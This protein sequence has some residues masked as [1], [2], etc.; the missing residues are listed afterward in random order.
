MV[1]L[2]HEFENGQQLNQ[3]QTSTSKA[4][5]IVIL[6]LGYLCTIY[7]NLLLC[8]GSKNMQK[9]NDQYTILT[10]NYII[11]YHVYENFNRPLKYVQIRINKNCGYVLD[12]LG[13]LLFFFNQY[14]VKN[15]P[16]TIDFL[17]L[18]NTVYT[19]YY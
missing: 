7:T 5:A 14:Y 15:D 10:F 8:F 16:Q 4:L 9:T 6:F 13:H 12:F 11:M 19:F 2:L 18:I 17:C 1:Y 3:S